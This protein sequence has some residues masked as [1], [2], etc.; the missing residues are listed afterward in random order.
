MIMEYESLYR[1]LS[2]QCCEC[3]V[4]AQ[5]PEKEI[6]VC[7]VFSFDWQYSGFKGHFPDRPVLP[8]IVQ[9]AAVRYMAEQGLGEKFNPARYSRVKFRGII[10]PEEKVVVH[11]KLTSSERS[12]AG[13]F[14]LQ[15][16][17]TEPKLVAS[18]YCQFVPVL[19]V[20][21]SV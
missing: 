2:S 14:S 12:W 7:G 3:H 17:G 5:V 1:S 8:A 11:L 4:A 13:N 18:G 19:D 16:Q 15:K 9:L 6:E 21:D 20:S 10:E